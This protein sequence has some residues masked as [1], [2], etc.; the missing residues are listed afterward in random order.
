LDFFNW[1][2]DNFRALIIVGFEMKSLF[3]LD[4]IIG[5]F[6]G[7]ATVISLFFPFPKAIG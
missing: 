7:F 3:G 5:L 6:V 4:I 2:F 1:L